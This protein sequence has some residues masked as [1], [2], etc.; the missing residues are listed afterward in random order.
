M[1]K[2]ERT[3]SQATKKANSK[4]RGPVQLAEFFEGEATEGRRF[5]LKKWN[6]LTVAGRQQVNLV[7]ADLSDLD[8]T[9]INLTYLNADR[10]SFA[11]SNLTGA[12]LAQG[13]FNKTCFAGATLHKAALVNASFEGADFSSCKMQEA[14]LTSSVCRNASF[15]GAELGGANLTGIHLLGAD[16]KD[17]MLTDAAFAGGCFDRDTRW[18]EGFLPPGDVLWHG[19]TTDPRLS[20]RGTRAVANDVNGLVARLHKLMDAN[21]MK[22]TLDMLKKEK[23]QL[24]FEVEETL[25]RGI[26]RSQ[27]NAN[28]VYS[29]VLTDNGTYS[30]ATPDVSRCMGL[31]N[32]PC[33]HLLV[34]VIGLVHAGKLD[35]T[36]ADRW[37]LAANE[38]GPRWNKTVKN[39]ICDSLLKYK[40]VVAGEVD[41]RPAETIPED[42]YAM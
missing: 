5:N 22:R 1:A 27:K 36:T 38:K 6:R 11:G 34:L 10:A 17:A 39:Y 42:Y 20:G 26:V 4:R 15:R 40:G 21:R 19:Q 25:V 8:L 16:L 31:S 3:A 9:G 23:H 2:S 37:M 18:P 12:R 14:D 33:K 32:E 30:C 28:L 35:P 29:C 13:R 24:Y 41:W 7:D